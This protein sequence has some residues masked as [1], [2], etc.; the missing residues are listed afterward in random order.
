MDR[1]AAFTPKLTIRS[2]LHILTSG[3]ERSEQRKLRVI[4]AMTGKNPG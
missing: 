4:G 3:L 1:C 2:T